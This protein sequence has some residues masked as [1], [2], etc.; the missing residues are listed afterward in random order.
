MKYHES[1]HDDNEIFTEY[2]SFSVKTDRHIGIIGRRAMVFKW[3]GKKM[4]LR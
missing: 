1:W 2:N 4:D 3:T